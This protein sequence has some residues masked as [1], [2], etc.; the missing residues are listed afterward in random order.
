[1]TTTSI[2]G[3]SRI[4]IDHTNSTYSLQHP[5]GGGHNNWQDVITADSPESFLKDYLNRNLNRIKA[6]PKKVAENVR[7]VLTALCEAP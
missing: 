3:N 2:N 5:T 4:V 6:Q 7:T 1:M